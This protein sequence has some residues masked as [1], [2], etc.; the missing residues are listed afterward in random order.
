MGVREQHSRRRQQP[1][2]TRVHIRRR[3][4]DPFHADHPVHPLILPHAARGHPRRA[5]NPGGRVPVL[6]AVVP[7]D[8]AP[9]QSKALDLM[10]TGSLTGRE[11]SAADFATLLDAAG[12]RLSRITPTG[13]VLSVVET[14]AA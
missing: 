12:L 6:D 11:R 8:N 7:D 4:P 5:L 3:H 9:H 14:V 1:P 10:M 2:P 13:T